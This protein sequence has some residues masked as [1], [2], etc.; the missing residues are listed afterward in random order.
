MT[1]KE[2][3]L[4]GL[5]ILVFALL[6]AAIFA[7][8]ALAQEQA[9]CPAPTA[10]VTQETPTSTPPV[11]PRVRLTSMCVVEEGV[12]RMRF[13]SENDVGP[14]SWSDNDGHSGVIQANETVFFEVTHPK[15]IVVKWES[16][17]FSGQTTKA[18]NNIPCESPTPTPEEP[19]ATPTV[20]ITP[21]Q[22]VCD[23]ENYIWIWDI[24]G[25]NGQVFQLRDRTYDG[26]YDAP[27]LDLQQR[28]IGCD[29]YPASVGGHWVN[30]CQGEY[31]YWDELPCWNGLGRCD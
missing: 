16:E 27:S 17:H 28:Y 20:E 5:L 31:G 11:K 14:I 24:V 19:T 4:F 21:T 23:P 6:V 8:P 22:T 25:P 26:T 1:N 12:G 2:R 9:A 7:I 13:R 29:F 10:T 3:L 30:D 18:Q 15:T